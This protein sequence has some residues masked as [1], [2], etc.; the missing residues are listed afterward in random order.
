M[1]ICILKV[2]LALK[3]GIV[4][5]S[6]APKCCIEAS[7]ALK[8]GILLS[9][10]LLPSP[11]WKEPVASSLRM[12]YFKALASLNDLHLFKVT[13]L[14]FYSFR[15]AV[16]P[17]SFKPCDIRLAAPEARYAGSGMLMILFKGQHTFRLSPTQTS[18]CIARYRTI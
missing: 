1:L 10:P 3:C 18:I 14:I 5:A 15:A 16:S 2:S 8:H 7:P 4:K 6:T 12:P 17:S 13:F 9:L 11:S